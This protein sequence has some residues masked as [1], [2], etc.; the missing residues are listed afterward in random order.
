MFKLLE[1]EKNSLKRNQNIIYNQDDYN[2]RLGV[3]GI[4]YLEPQVTLFLF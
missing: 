3:L 1:E 4:P 2:P